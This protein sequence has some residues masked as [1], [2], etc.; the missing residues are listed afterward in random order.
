[1][2]IGILIPVRYGQSKSPKDTMDP[3]GANLEKHLEYAWKEG[4]RRKTEVNFP[5]CCYL[6]RANPKS[7]TSKR[8]TLKAKV[9]KTYYLK[10]VEEVLEYHNVA[11]AVIT[12]EFFL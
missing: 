1:M 12:G 8:A 3:D 4:L 2:S 11:S 5:T 9:I 10:D 7:S 6:Y